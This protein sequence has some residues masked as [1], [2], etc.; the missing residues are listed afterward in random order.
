MP[1]PAYLL[2]TNIV[3]DLV[4]LPIAAHAI[5]HGLILVTANED[6]CS[7]VPGLVVENWLSEGS[8]EPGAPDAR[9]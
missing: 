8:D 4:H 6:E 7:R 1:K 2:D 5:A 3:S 9:Q